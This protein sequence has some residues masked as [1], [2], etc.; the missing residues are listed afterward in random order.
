[1]Y[2]PINQWAEDDR[3]REKFLLKGKAAL[4]DS[5]LLAILIGSGTRNESA[6][7]LCQRILASSNH[8]LTILSKL[9]IAQLMQFKGIGE[10]K[11][12]TIA[13]ALE[14]G[15]RRRVE[16]AV[17]LEKITS[18]KDV[19]ELMQPIIGELAHEEFWVIYLNNANK[20][21]YKSQISKGGITGT[22]VDSRVIF[23]IAFEYNATALILLHN[24]PS[25]KLQASQADITLT[26]NLQQASKSLE[27]QILDHIIITENHYFSFADE[28]I[29]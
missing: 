28:G 25:G 18:S 19:F 8:N 22:L 14:L 3:P 11:A 2:M 27:I 5:E 7:Q 20:I 24:H 29:L 1:M 26:K 13:A 6:V 21:I 17:V 9:S 10:A 16:E 4:S 12:I 15:R 23:K